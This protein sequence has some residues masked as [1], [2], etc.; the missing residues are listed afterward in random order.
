M[1][2]LGA[3]ELL[4]LGVLGVLMVL[5]FMFVVRGVWG[6]APNPRRDDEGR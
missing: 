3:Q 6:G 1:F 4:I 5:V 2:G